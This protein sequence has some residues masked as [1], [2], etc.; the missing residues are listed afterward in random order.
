MEIFRIP[1]FFSPP[2]FDKRLIARS[3]DISRAQK[4]RRQMPT[5]SI[6]FHPPTEA[7]APYRLPHRN[8]IFAD[9][10]VRFAALAE[11][12]SQGDWLR[13][14]EQLSLAQH[15]ILKGL[16]ALP[17]PDAASLK[18]ARAQRKPP[19]DASS[20]SR[21]AAWRFAL[22]QLSLRLE[23]DAPEAAQKA[24][25]ILFST[26]E[27]ELENLADTLLAGE[28]DIERAAQLPFVAAALQ[29]A[30]TALA[31]QLEA[32]QL[33]P[34]NVHGACPCC[35]SQP[36]ASIIRLGDAINNPR[37][38]RC[39]LCNTEWNVP[40]AACSACDTDADIALHEIEGLKGTVRAETCNACKSYLKVVYQENDSLVDP[41]A[42]DL[43]TQA[44]DTVLDEAG[45]ERVAPKQLL[46]GA[47]G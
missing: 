16:P 20:L 41:V 10:A 14:F 44:L 26:R 24:L 35:G 28:P 45:Y 39:S 19:L 7:A 37:Y 27:A 47:N 11:D 13:F 22:Q 21:P 9:R 2:P 36:V 1:F 18:Q 5:Q 38:L 3:Q 23:N 43:A 31:S 40:R 8:S 4:A 6:D 42:D 30:F 46:I 32:S 33:Q 29:V 34:L 17:L 15:Q 12:N 25:K